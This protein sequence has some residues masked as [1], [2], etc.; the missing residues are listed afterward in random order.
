MSPRCVLVLV[1]YIFVSVVLIK[2]YWRVAGSE[3]ADESNIGT[4]TG[5]SKVPQN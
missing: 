4:V 5:R 1:I 2:F 3:C